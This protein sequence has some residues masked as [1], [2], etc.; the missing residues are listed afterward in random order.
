MVLHENLSAVFALA[1]EDLAASWVHFRV[2]SDIVD[3]ALVYRPAVILFVM[4]A[5]LIKCQH[6]VVRIL[7]H[8][9]HP[10][11]LLDELLHR[12]QHIHS[13][14]I[15]KRKVKISVRL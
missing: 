4:L 14:G 8:G 10:S 6:H 7:H 12:V 3:A 13:Q 1:K 11:I 15:R 2:L 5:D 9:L